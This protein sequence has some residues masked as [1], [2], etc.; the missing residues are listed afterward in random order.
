MI[1]LEV[2]QKLSKNPE[3]WVVPERNIK[4]WLEKG[5]CNKAY[6]EWKKIFESKSKESILKL[7]SEKSE[8]STRL[9][10]SSPFA[11]VLT[12]EERNKYFDNK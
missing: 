4:K 6:S 1:H 11:G 3:M 8:L 2:A 5:C 9:R 7:I 12:S 10:S